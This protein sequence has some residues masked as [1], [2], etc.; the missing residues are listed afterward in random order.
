MLACLCTLG[1]KGRPDEAILDAWLVGMRRRRPLAVGSL[2][3]GGVLERLPDWLCLHMVR[4]NSNVVWKDG[5]AFHVRRI[6]ACDYTYPPRSI[7]TDVFR[8]LVTSEGLRFLIKMVGVDRLAWDDYH[9]LGG[10]AAGRLMGL[11]HGWMG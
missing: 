4:C 11:S 6:Y 8:F 7:C 5:Q 1:L 3:L 10:N 9:F 2:I